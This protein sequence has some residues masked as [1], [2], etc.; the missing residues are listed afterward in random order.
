MF[1]LSN[2]R[3]VPVIVIGSE[4]VVGFDRR[5]LDEALKAAGLA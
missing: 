3:T 5:R 4:V 2:S 1:A